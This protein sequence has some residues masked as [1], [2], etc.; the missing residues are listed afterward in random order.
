VVFFNYASK[1]ITTKIVYYG[2]GLSGKTTNLQYLYE[3]LPSQGKG[4]MLSLKTRDDR[5]LFFDFL[6]IDLGTIKGMRIRLQLCTV[7]GQVFYNSTR[8]LVLKGVDGVVFV[9][10][11][12]EGKMDANLKSLVNLEQNL[13]EQGK[14]LEKIPLVIQ[15]NKRDLDPLMPADVMNQK[16][17]HLGVPVFEGIATRG[18]GVN[19]ALIEITRLVLEDL[20]RKHH[21]DL[22]TQA[23][24]QSLIVPEP[25]GEDRILKTRGP[26]FA[27]A[28]DEGTQAAEEPAE[29]AA[30][31]PEPVA[32][33]P[34]EKTDP[35]VEPVTD[36]R[37]GPTDFEILQQ[38]NGKS[39]PGVQVEASEPVAE[40][41]FQEDS[42]A[43]AGS[44]PAQETAVCV[45][46]E[47]EEIEVPVSVTLDRRA[48]DVKLKLNI[49]ITFKE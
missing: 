27:G 11:S 10:D 1:E 20:K 17:N 6:P 24:L 18:E 37:E 15:L 46:E 39:A 7:P 33:P 43:D 40:I 38:M 9:A 13:L 34:A 30:S 25:E 2:P 4:K 29:E 48:A 47:T 12:Q 22:D 32:E 5:T 26:L 28:E 31:P 16:L 23:S 44:R 36:V 8:K 45:A 42:G 35:A 19:D 21:L 14:K 3:T 49:K 41:G